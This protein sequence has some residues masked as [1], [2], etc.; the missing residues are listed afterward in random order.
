MGK[1][2]PGALLSDLEFA[3]YTIPKFILEWPAHG[4]LA[5]KEDY[6]LAPFYDY[7]GDGNYNPYDGDY[8]GYELVVGE[9]DCRVSRN[10]SLYGDRNLW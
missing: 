5:N 7:N 4:N 10:V 9:N 2:D 1:N 8:P 6:Y 3:G